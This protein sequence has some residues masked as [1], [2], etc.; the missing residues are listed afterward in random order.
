MNSSST[1]LIS[2]SSLLLS[3]TAHAD[4]FASNC[5]LCPYLIVSVLLCIVTYTILSGD[6]IVSIESEELPLVN[7]VKGGLTDKVIVSI[8]VISLYVL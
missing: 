4:I 3:Y 2:G 1:M 5:F 8:T 6:I 7:S